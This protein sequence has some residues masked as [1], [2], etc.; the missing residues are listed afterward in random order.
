MADIP[1]LHFNQQSQQGKAWETYTI[2]I[3]EELHW[4]V[5]KE[6]RETAH[7]EHTLRQLLAACRHDSIISQ[8]GGRARGMSAPLSPSLY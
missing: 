8:V 7:S 1:S 2:V 5:S 3:P 4:A 6:A